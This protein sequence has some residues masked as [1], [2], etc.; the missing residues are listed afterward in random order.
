MELITV[1]VVGFALMFASDVC[2]SRN[3]FKG[4]NFLAF[5]G[6]LILFSSSVYILTYGEGMNIS[7][8]YRIISGLFTLIFLFLLV[9]SVVIEVNKKREEDE[10][11]ITTGTYALTRHPGV[12]WFLLYYLFGSILFANYDILIAGLVWSIANVIYVLLQEKLV[13][14]KIFDNYDVYTKTTPML[15]PNIT[16]IRKCIKTLNG[17][18]NERFTSDV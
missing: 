12:I 8:T 10:K 3:N 2:G 4:R 17:G 1:G 9:Y 14:N 11:L 18:H 5:F 15:L 6:V 16:S 13:F 7:F